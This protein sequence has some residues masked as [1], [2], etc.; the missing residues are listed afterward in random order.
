MNSDQVHDPIPTLNQSPPSTPIASSSLTSSPLTSPES[1][2]L[3]M[4]SLTDVY[5]RSQQIL[6]SEL[7]DFALFADA[8][9]EEFETAV[10]NDKRRKAMDSKI[11]SVLKND[12]WDLVDLPQGHKSIGVKWV[13]KTKLN[14][15]GD[16]EKHK[17]RLV[18]KGYKQKYG[19][20]YNEVFAPVIC[21]ETI[22][23]VVFLAAQRNWK[24]HQ[25]DVKSA[26]LN[27]YLNEEV[28]IDQP[29]GYIKDHE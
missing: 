9:L 2:P 10:K 13:Y 22:R 1:T 19:T 15:N 12:T 20:D 25:M 3:K 21:L 29:P 26:F 23:L 8:D 14:K 7:V 18:V 5:A 17:A 27:G 24:L 28:Y 4:K 6:D 11:E 16:I